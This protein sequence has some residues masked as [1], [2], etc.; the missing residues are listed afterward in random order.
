[1]HAAVVLATHRNLTAPAA[2]ALVLQQNVML[3]Q[4]G[5]AVWRSAPSHVV[6]QPSCF[7][8]ARKALV[9]RG[10]CH[11]T[12]HQA[13][14]TPKREV[15]TVAYPSHVA[16]SALRRALREHPAADTVL[17]G[18]LV[19]TLTQGEL[20]NGLK[21]LGLD[22]VAIAAA[23]LN[24]PAPHQLVE[25]PCD[26]LPQAETIDAP[27]TIEP[28]AIETELQGIRSLIG[29]GGFAALDDKL[30]S[31][32]IEARKPPV[33]VQVRVEVPVDVVPGAPVHAAKRT[34]RTET[35]RSLF[36]VKGVMG[37]NET[38]LWDGSHPTT[39]AIN[40]RYIWPHPATEIALSQLKRGRN[41]FLTGPKG[42]GKTDWATQLAARTG[43]PLA[44]ISC[45]AGTDAA[46]LVGM[47][48]P[49]AAGGVTWQD[50]QLTRAI[51]TPG[52]VVCIDEPS[53]ARAGALFV[54]QNILQNRV[55][56]ISE[57]GQQVKVAPGVVFVACDNTNGT[58]GGS[59]RGYTDTNRLNAAFLDRFGVMVAFDYLPAKDEAQAIV[60][61]TG[62]TVELAELLVNAATVT[63]QAADAQTLQHGIGLRRLLSWAEL[64]QD[65]IDPESAFCSAVLNCATEQDREALREQCLLT[66]DRNTVARALNPSSPVVLDPAMVNPTPQGRAAA[67]DFPDAFAIPAAILNA[68]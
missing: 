9:L 29:S 8:S 30:R 34:G 16:R 11:D 24:A 68:R 52:C 35:W 62:C 5:D 25:L 3:P 38:E 7:C 44:L 4:R 50:G 46:T 1:V 56:F 21:T 53:V 37:K 22:H 10:A 59:R 42:T 47:T 54:F 14:T 40:D 18:R 45:D 6:L 12:T 65:G 61:Y 20:I 23:A 17:A 67:S 51:R 13:Y 19:N 64:L 31:L 27:G 26:N 66:Y 57:T 39:P 33:E 55:M 43:R 32:V 28:D 58:G 60:S 41:V 63:R 49:D 36:G 2:F 15:N 48:V